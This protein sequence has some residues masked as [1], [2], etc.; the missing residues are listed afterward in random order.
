M[1]HLRST[2]LIFIGKYCQ[3][4]HRAI[5]LRLGQRSVSYFP[6]FCTG[7]LWYDGAVEWPGLNH[8]ATGNTFSNLVV[9]EGRSLVQT[10]FTPNITNNVF[11]NISLI[12]GGPG[13]L[14]IS[15]ENTFRSDNATIAGNFF[16]D[17]WNGK[18]KKL[19][20]FV[21]QGD[22]DQVFVQMVLQLSW[23]SQETVL[24]TWLPLRTIDSWG[25]VALTFPNVKLDCSFLAVAVALKWCFNWSVTS[26][27]VVL[28]KNGLVNLGA[29]GF[30]GVRTGADTVVL[31][32]NIFRNNE[33]RPV[34]QL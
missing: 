2:V 26:S 21:L 3:W 14:A 25:V 27:S 33:V 29:A 12:G 34:F 31:A 19:S 13:L 5:L 17:I 22:W 11:S 9:T 7:Y 6:F 23:A 15:A 8:C 16:R 18:K 4:R 10:K 28:E 1:P 20:R 24:I 30:T 32:D